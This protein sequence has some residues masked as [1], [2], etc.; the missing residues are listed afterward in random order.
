MQGV[1]RDQWKP[2]HSL[3][4]CS[5][6][7]MS[8]TCAGP[9]RPH[10]FRALKEQS[11]ISEA[12]RQTDRQTDRQAD[13]QAD[14]QTDRIRQASWTANVLYTLYCTHNKPHFDDL[15]VS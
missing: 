6:S 8:F 1:H 12:D 14:R 3:T 13:R 7:M 4:L 2:Q 5:H 11:D 9:P 10:S 15:N